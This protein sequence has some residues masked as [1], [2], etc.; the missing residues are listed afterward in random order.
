VQVLLPG[1]H[2]AASELSRPEA[3]VESPSPLESSEPAVSFATSSSSENIADTVSS[4]SQEP[5]AYLPGSSPLEPVPPFPAIP[6]VDA[7]LA[8]P[9][10]T[11]VE[12][13]QIS[14]QVPT[15]G[16]LSAQSGARPFGLD[17]EM[18]DTVEKTKDLARLTVVDAHGRTAADHYV[19]PAAR[20]IEYFYQFSGITPDL[21]RKATADLTSV[22]IALAASLAPG[23][24]GQ[25][26]TLRSV[27]HPSAILAGHGLENDLR[28]LRL[29]YDR[30]ADSA[31]QFEHRRGLPSRSSLKFLCLRQ[32]GREIRKS[33]SS[34]PGL[35]VV[36]HDSAEDASCALELLLR[37]CASGPAWGVQH[38]TW[39]HVPTYL[40]STRNST[41][42]S[43]P[44][45]GGKRKRIE[46]TPDTML[47]AC[48]TVNEAP[49]AVGFNDAL[50]PTST[51]IGSIG[52]CR[53]H[54][55]GGSHIIEID[56]K[57]HVSSQSKATS[58]SSVG[59]DS[60]QFAGSI[61]QAVENEIHVETTE[62]DAEL[63]I[64]PPMLPHLVLAEVQLGAS[65]LHKSKASINELIQFDQSLA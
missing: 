9:A 26:S 4:M 39:G 32:L 14:F 5:S 63:A 38:R 44:K 62:P 56:A 35:E 55:S 51:V 6:M 47:G 61:L 40:H 12:L 48:V 57:S 65:A 58:A 19:R 34:V 11:S 21:M 7:K 46:L 18:V 41:S 64:R 49:V 10:L 20:I 3:F 15:L 13:D 22:R 2:D 60:N 16:S 45:A 42:G 30:I 36:P 1:A 31:L 24:D 52:F 29:C 53:Q 59:Q 25:S 23:E 50:P 43:K 17:C 54:A 37:R 27:L 28:S 8:K 33:A